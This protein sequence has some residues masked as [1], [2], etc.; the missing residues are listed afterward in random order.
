M[1]VREELENF[2]Y[3]ECS[4]QNFCSLAYGHL[5]MMMMMMMM[6]MFVSKPCFAV[7]LVLGYVLLQEVCK[8]Q[9]AR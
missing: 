4:S 8:H 9:H 3:C 6:T 1:F 2:R 7:A 5:M